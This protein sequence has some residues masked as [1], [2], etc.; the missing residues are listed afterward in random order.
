MIPRRWSAIQRN[1][2]LRS[3]YG[4][5]AVKCFKEIRDRRIIPPSNRSASNTH[6]SALHIST[7]AHHLSGNAFSHTSSPST[8]PASGLAAG[9]NHGASPSSTTTLTS[10]FLRLTKPSPGLGHA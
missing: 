10:F 6:T 5:E 3:V 8:G 2:T 7:D 1:S 4:W 9:V